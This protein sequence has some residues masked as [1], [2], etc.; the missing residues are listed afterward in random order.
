[1]SSNYIDTIPLVQW[2]VH[3]SIPCTVLHWLTPMF[4]TA[5]YTGSVLMVPIRTFHYRWWRWNGE[6]TT[7]DFWHWAADLI[8]VLLAVQYLPILTWK[9]GGRKW[10]IRTQ[11]CNP[12]ASP[13]NLQKNVTGNW[14]TRR[15]VKSNKKYFTIA[16]VSSSSHYALGPKSFQASLLTS[17]LSNNIEMVTL[18]CPLCIWIKSYLLNDKYVW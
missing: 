3:L 9:Q 17:L 16:P 14:N 6:F 18:R 11:T 1:M 4:T 2:S 7:S 15:K 13:L 10:Y 8:M 5:C 12:T